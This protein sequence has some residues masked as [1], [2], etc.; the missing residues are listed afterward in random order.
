MMQECGEAYNI[1]SKPRGRAVIVNIEHF[2]TEAKLKNRTGSSVDAENLKNLF[3]DLCF[4]VDTLGPY[5]TAQV[6]GFIKALF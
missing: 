6:N 1:R 2:D 4:K 5:V 3:E